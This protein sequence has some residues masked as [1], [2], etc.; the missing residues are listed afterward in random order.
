MDESSLSEYSYTLSGNMEM[1]REMACE[2]EKKEKVKQIKV[3]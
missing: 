1:V 2:R 3:L